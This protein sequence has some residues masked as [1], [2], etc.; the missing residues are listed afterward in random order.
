MLSL[1]RFLAVS[2]A[3]LLFCAAAAAEQGFPEPRV[4][5]SAQSYTQ[6]G[7]V[8]L[9]S[10]VYYT[11]GK[12]RREIEDGSV[13]MIARRDKNVVWELFPGKKTYVELKLNG[14]GASSRP[15]WGDYRSEFRLQRKAVGKESV[16]G[17][18]A[19]KS[20]FTMTGPQ[21]SV[22]TG[23]MW[24]TKE[25]IVVRMDADEKSN[26]AGAGLRHRLEGLSVGPQDP[27]LF[28]VP[29]GYKK[30]SAPGG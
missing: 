5:Y 16:G 14:P 12:E 23:F 21:G 22:M 17:V 7:A 26:A 9:R 24:T 1:K 4:G 27:V 10:K 13:V 15:A 28:E 18:E 11:P 19:T 29:P 20:R 2:A 30:M 3:I 6:N 8:T 25:G